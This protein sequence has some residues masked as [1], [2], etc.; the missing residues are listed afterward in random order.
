MA[1]C[2]FNEMLWRKRLVFLSIR[3]NTASKLQ[4]TLVCMNS[5]LHAVFNK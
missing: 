5:A 3:E 4:T 1:C 2:R